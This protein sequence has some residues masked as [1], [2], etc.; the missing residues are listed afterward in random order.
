MPT[1]NSALGVVVWVGEDAPVGALNEIDVEVLVAG[2]HADAHDLVAIAP[3]L[4]VLGADAADRA[5]SFVAALKSENALGAVPVAAQQV[6][7]AGGRYGLV[8]SLSDNIDEATTEIAAL[9]RAR[10]GKTKAGVPSGRPRKS[11]FWIGETGPVHLRL[12]DGGWFPDDE[13]PDEGSLVEIAP[14]RIVVA[15]STAGTPLNLKGARVVI[16]HDDATEALQWCNALSGAG[17]KAIHLSPGTIDQARKLVPSVLVVTRAALIARSSPEPWAEERFVGASVVVVDDEASVDEL[18]AA[19]NEGFTTELSIRQKLGQWQPVHG[20]LETFGAARWLKVIGPLKETFVF[21]VRGPGLTVAIQLSGG[22]I[23]SAKGRRDSGE[24]LD[25]KAAIG[26]LLS[27]AAGRVR[28][29][30]AEQLE[31]WISELPARALPLDAETDSEDKS[32]SAADSTSESD[33]DLKSDSDFKSDSD[34]GVDSISESEPDPNA[35]SSSD[36]ENG[37][38]FSSD[39][40]SPNDADSAPA[41]KQTAQAAKPPK[42][43]APARPLAASRPGPRPFVGLPKPGA[44]K[45]KKKGPYAVPAPKGAPKAGPSGPLS[46]PRLPPVKLPA[47]AALPGAAVATG[48]PAD[49]EDDFDIDVEEPIVVPPRDD[50]PVPSLP[51][52]ISHAGSSKASNDPFAFED[53]EGDDT[54]IDSGQLLENLDAATFGDEDEE[55]TRIRAPLSARPDKPERA[56]ARPTPRPALQPTSQPTGQS[57]HAK[58]SSP[59]SKRAPEKTS[60]RA[61]PQKSPAATPLDAGPVA[62]REKA[63]LFPRSIP[64]PPSKRAALFTIIFMIA[65]GGSIYFAWRS[66]QVPPH[67]P[68]VYTDAAQE[69]EQATPQASPTEQSTTP[70]PPDDPIDPTAAAH[71]EVETIS[72]DELELLLG[73]IR[74][75]NR[76]EDFATAEQFARRGRGALPG[77][78][79]IAYQLAMA[80]LGQG[81]GD[82]ALEHARAAAEID[83]DIDRYHLLLGDIHT[84]FGRFSSARIAYRNCLRANPNFRPCQARL[85][86]RGGE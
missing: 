27:L 84:R 81:R 67:Q 10:A 11:G 56:S 40:D 9:L 60:A 51:S 42:P 68:R 79:E 69:S 14:G 43:I 64:P 62:Y 4:I 21:D 54:I 24:S 2:L 8:A 35:G 70:E 31:N 45:P 65:A 28:L 33:S 7:Q 20:R 66:L 44:P 48:I 32:D 50:G 59:P 72:A 73:T 1:P 83:P 49:L 86:Q 78:S 52:P 12:D 18:V 6:E 13:V 3:D 80:L 5:D 46:K 15:P 77:N 76:D 22:K 16:A 63:S 30:T 58:K 53:D 82:Q 25:G 19:V 29:G 75:A 71:F 41:S 26:A 17:A 38:D 61:A 36:S 47:V 85:E 23:K 74:R 55:P 57:A 39:S 37:S 34:G